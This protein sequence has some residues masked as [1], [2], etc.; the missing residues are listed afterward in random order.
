MT[1]KEFY[2]LLEQHDWWYDFS[3]DKSV[4]MKGYMSEKKIIKAFTEQEE[5]KPLY[6][7]Y[8]KYI[9]GERLKPVLKEN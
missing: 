4:F 7:E 8:V 5:F 9:N 1:I 6:K 2:K 3:D